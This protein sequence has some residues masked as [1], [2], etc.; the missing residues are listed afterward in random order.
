MGS[1]SLTP[2]TGLRAPR[3][4]LLNPPQT[5]ASTPFTDHTGNRATSAYYGHSPRPGA[6]V[7][8]P[9]WSFHYYITFGAKAA[10]ETAS[11][12]SPSSSLP[13]ALVKATKNP[14]LEPH[15]FRLDIYF[16]PGASAEAC[17]THYRAERTSRLSAPPPRNFIDSYRDPYSAFSML[18]QVESPDWET[19]GATLALFD[20]TSRYDGEGEQPSTNVDR[21]VPW[22]GDESVG[23][24]LQ[25]MAGGTRRDEMTNAYEERLREGHSDWA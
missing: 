7:L 9:L 10:E 15:P 8:P 19:E 3:Q 24:R 23:I 2:E 6:P 12:S 25:R 17:M 4:S 18:V 11:S 13:E 21:N 5:I 22:G 20:M 16:L 14:L 1:N